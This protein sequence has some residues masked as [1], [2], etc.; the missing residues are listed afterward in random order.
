ME[1]IET[2]NMDK[3]ESGCPDKARSRNFHQAK[4]GRLASMDRTSPSVIFLIHVS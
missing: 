4:N 2:K 1:E 3:N